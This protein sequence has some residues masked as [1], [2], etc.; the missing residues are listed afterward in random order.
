MQRIKLLFYIQ[1]LAALRYGFK[2]VNDLIVHV[3]QGSALGTDDTRKN[4]LLNP[5]T[6]EV[7]G[8]TPTPC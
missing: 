4:S 1:I 8:S 3:G 7:I 2:S 5:L 6:P